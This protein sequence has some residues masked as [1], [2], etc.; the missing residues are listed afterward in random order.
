MFPMNDP[1]MLLI[2]TMAYV[3]H[4]LSFGVTG[5]LTY[6]PPYLLARKIL[7]PRPPEQR[8]HQ[9][10]D[11]HRLSGQRRARWDFRRG[12]NYGGHHDEAKITGIAALGARLLPDGSDTF[13]RLLL[14]QPGE[15]YAF[16]EPRGDPPAW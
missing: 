11:R 1:P 8:A 13:R 14:G 16:R 10:E 4:H 2:P 9:L 7:R 5:N 12:H 3:T 15:E 6:E